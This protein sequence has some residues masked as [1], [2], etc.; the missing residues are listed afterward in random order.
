MYK[1]VYLGG[2]HWYGLTITIVF[3]V[4]RTIF[5]VITFALYEYPALQIQLFICL[6]VMYI[7]YLD[8]SR[9]YQL[10]KTLRFEYLNEGTFLVICYHLILFTNIVDTPSTNNMIGSS[11]IVWI[12]FLAFIN[13]S[14][15]LKSSVKAVFKKVM[16]R[17]FNQSR[18]ISTKE[19]SHSSALS[20]EISSQ[21][22]DRKER[23]ELRQLFVAEE[24]QEE[25]I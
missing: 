5:L 2:G 14:A 24:L 11:L 16:A 13:I 6:S 20:N 10:D 22:K 25:D 15:M 21:M 3:L 9:I 8:Q 4:R 19:K 1:D 18:K 17:W 7:T 23:K 12:L